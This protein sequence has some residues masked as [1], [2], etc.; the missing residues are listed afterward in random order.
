L[1]DPYWKERMSEEGYLQTKIRELQEKNEEL[2]LSLEKQKIKL[3]VLDKRL[4]LELNNITKF[5]G[6]IN[7]INLSNL[8][9]E[10]DEF[11]KE[12]ITNYI[13]KIQIK[14]LNKI[15]T[16]IEDLRIHA[17]K[18]YI[19]KSEESEEYVLSKVLAVF[20]LL[21]NILEKKNII[22]NEVEKECIKYLFMNSKQLSKEENK[23]KRE[24]LTITDTNKLNKIF[25]N[26]IDTVI[27][28]LEDATNERNKLI[29]D[30]TKGI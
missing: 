17:T 27:K 13:N 29:T 7:S 18:E 14:E 4:N 6:E 16:H 12:E 5:K 2:V 22:L 20:Q 26:K 19:K 11:I 10:I 21:F 3:E 8:K 23:I 1:E 25:G 15:E 24:T 9:L 30:L 28:K